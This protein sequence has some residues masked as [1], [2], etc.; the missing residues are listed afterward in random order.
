[1][2]WSAGVSDPFDS[3]VP[4]LAR[5]AIYA[6]PPF[7][8]DATVQSLR[9][10]PSNEVDRW[11][12]RVYRR[13]L[14]LGSRAFAVS[15]AQ[16]GAGPG[17]ALQVEWQGI[18]FGA[19]RKAVILPMLSRMLGLNLALK[20][21]RRLAA[22]DARL[23]RLTQGAIGLK[24]ARFPTVFEAL[25]NA[26]ACRA[27]PLPEGIARLNRLC[28]RFGPRYG[29]AF[30]FPRPTDLAGLAVADLRSLDWSEPDAE[31]LLELARQITVG[32]LDL[33][34]MSA[35]EDAAL[36]ERLSALPGMGRWEAQSVALRGFGRLDAVPA[37]DP[38]L[39]LAAQAWLGLAQCPT[40]EQLLEALRSWAPFRGMA[41]LHLL[42][43][44][45][46]PALPH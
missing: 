37:A 3:S 10:E 23:Q 30:G 6:A 33:D 38:A 15:M 42:L 28:E 34:A 25:A 43:S 44:Q 13:V 46:R 12:G 41:S 24:P 39:R 4:A 27:G 5:C 31:R 29:G 18:G 26:I 17:A 35:L 19:E 40:P 11:D 16:P 8:L 45:A 21:W 20:P 32:G 14:T 36:V 9:R 22:S 7:R 2:S 1:M